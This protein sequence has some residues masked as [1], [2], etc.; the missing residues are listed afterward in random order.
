MLVKIL[1]IVTVYVYTVK[2]FNQ[3]FAGDS[4]CNTFAFS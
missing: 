1:C 4:K 3:V 2:T